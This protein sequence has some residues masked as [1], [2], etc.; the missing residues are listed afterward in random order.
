MQLKGKV[1]KRQESDK[2]ADFESNSPIIIGQRGLNH[3]ELQVI[4]YL[5]SFGMIPAINVQRPLN[6]LANGH[7]YFEAAQISS[8]LQRARCCKPH[9]IC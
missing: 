3:L 6:N 1:S 8:W 5:Q 4:I 7:P 2:L 9:E